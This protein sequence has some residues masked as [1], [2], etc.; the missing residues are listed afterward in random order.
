[1]GLTGHLDFDG[2]PFGDGGP[3]AFQ[4]STCGGV[5]S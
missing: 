5:V 1:M 4:G 2:P 3:L